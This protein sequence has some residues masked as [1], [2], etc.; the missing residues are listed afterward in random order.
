MSRI[1]IVH[2]VR[3]GIANVA[4]ELAYGARPIERKTLHWTHP[5]SLEARRR[6]WVYPTADG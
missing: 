1:G 4:L 2:I 5:T 6:R 3:I